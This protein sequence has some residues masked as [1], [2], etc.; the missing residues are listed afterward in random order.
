M[1]KLL[2]RTISLDSDADPNVLGEFFRDH[3]FVGRFG[4]YDTFE[5]RDDAKEIDAETISQFFLSQMGHY[6]SESDFWWELNYLNPSGY[7][8]LTGDVIVEAFWWWDGD[9][10]LYF[11]MSDRITGAL[12]NFRTIG[13][14]DCKK[15]YG[16]FDVRG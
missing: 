9:G 7:K 6:E 10:Q 1:T 12:K 2:V 11:R 4:C 8:F 14:T 13:N 15:Q 16:W 3:L 5:V